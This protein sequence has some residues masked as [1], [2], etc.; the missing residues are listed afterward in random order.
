MLSYYIGVGP[1][2]TKRSYN[3]M[4]DDQI[5]ELYFQRNEAAIA[6]TSAKYGRL[7]K[8]IATNV[9]NNYSDSEEC[10]NDTYHAAWK[11]IPP[12]KP[13]NLGVFL[14]KIARNI[15]LD[16]FD[17]NRAGKRNSNFAV[18]LSE[19]EEILSS[20][21]NPELALEEAELTKH[22]NDFLRQNEYIKRVVFVRRYWYS[23]SIEEIA[24]NYGFSQS[25]VKSMLKRTR[26]SLKKYLERQGVRL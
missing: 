14:G 9:L 21:D 18:S 23:D 15:A 7:L 22:I 17:Y 1:T 16:K 2:K 24:T 26:E 10:V 12:E 25:K 4:N 8:S 5:V 20:K 3:T 6:E 11:L 19:L 13:N